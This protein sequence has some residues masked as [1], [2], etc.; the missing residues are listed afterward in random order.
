MLGRMRRRERADW[1]GTGLRTTLGVIWNSEL[2]V[3]KGGRKC[4]FKVTNPT[5]KP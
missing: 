2:F 4:R 3:V 1:E 5:V